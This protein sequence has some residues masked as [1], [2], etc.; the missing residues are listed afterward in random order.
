[1]EQ[2]GTYPL[3]ESQLDRFSMRLSLGY[4]DPDT[5]VQIIRGENPLEKV[6]RIIPAVKPQELISTIHQIKKFYV[7]PDVGKFVVEIVSQTRNH[8]DV[9]LGV[10]TRGAIHL[11]SCAKA[12][13]YIKGR[14]F[15]VPE[16]VIE[17]SP[18]V[19]PHRIITRNEADPKLLVEEILTKIKIP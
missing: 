15:V 9:V 19:L 8:P 6:D 4:P 5:E 7:S 10:S 13:A 3:P 18:L 2:Y 1:M 17:L 12:L 11:V 16:D 14:D